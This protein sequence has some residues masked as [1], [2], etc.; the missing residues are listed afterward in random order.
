MPLATTKTRQPDELEE[1]PEVPDDIQRDRWKRP[2]IVPKAGGPPIAYTRASTLGKAIEDNFHLHK[3]EMRAVALGMSRREDLVALA[4]AIPE[5]EGEHRGPLDDIAKEA[6]TAGG[7]DKGANIGTALHKLSER[8]DAGEDLTYLRSIFLEAMDA[9]SQQM[10]PFKVL[11]AETFVAC[12]EVQT[13]G[14]FDRV[15]QLRY[16]LQFNQNLDGQIVSHIIPAGTVLILDLKTGKYD[17]AKYW[18]AT[19]SVQ[20]TVYAMGDPYTP[21]GRRT[22]GDLLG[23]GMRP[24]TDWALILHV[25]SDSPK[26]AGLHVVDLELGR[27]LAD[28]AIQVRNA[29]KHKGLL[30]PGYIVMD[31]GVT[32]EQVPVERPAIDAP[33]DF[34]LGELIQQAAD[35]ATL[36]DL[37]RQHRDLWGDEHTEAV[38]TRLAELQAPKAIDAPPAKTS[39]EVKLEVFA[40]LKGAVSVDSIIALHQAHRDIWDDDCKRMAKVRKAEL[41][42]VQA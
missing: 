13:A 34:G 3:W 24:S 35:E 22:W 40:A 1:I 36:K 15:V 5:N 12:D 6:K 16:N 21:K 19:Y 18:G 7:G 32:V 33:A 38:K 25:P 11:A 28:L 2:L 29:R 17:S 41:E 42:A 4:S 31:Q 14:T 37:Y 23:E 39:H 27:A 10:G 30:T 26:D 9:Y 20:Q 8:R